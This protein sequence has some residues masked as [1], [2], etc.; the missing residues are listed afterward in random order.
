MFEFLPVVVETDGILLNAVLR[1]SMRSGL[2]LKTPSFLAEISDRIPSAGG[3]IEASVFAHLAELNTNITVPALTGD[4]D[5]LLRVDEEFRIE[6]GA[7][8]GA[9]VFLGDRSWG[10]TPST[11][12]PL[13]YTTIADKCAL[14]PSDIATIEG[15]QN[16][17]EDLSTTSTVTKKTYT[18]VQCLSTGLV[19]CPASLQSVHKFTVTETLSSAVPTGVLVD[20]DSSV[21]AAALSV[22]KFGSDVRSLLKTSGPVLSFIPPPEPTSSGDGI[23]F[24]NPTEVVDD[25]VRTFGEVLEGS[26][27]GVSNKIIIGVSVGV[28]VPLVIGSIVG[29]M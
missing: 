13:F 26:T 12:T 16:D 18:G 28:G 10:P 22:L 25:V 4:D 15:R 14:A 9:S 8:A 19:E 17:D 11:Q 1:L 3:G 6:I 24:P 21:G 29:I 20:W 7:A 23:S 2:T 27:G 5:C